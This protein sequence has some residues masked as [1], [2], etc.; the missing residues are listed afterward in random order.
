[1]TIQK[2]NNALLYGVSGDTKPTNYA[3]NTIFFEQDTGSTYRSVSGSWS[4]FSGASKTETLSNK[5]I[6]AELQT[7]ISKVAIAPHVRDT[8]WASPYPANVFTQG[9]MV[10]WTEMG[11]KAMVAVDSSH[12]ISSTYTTAATANSVQGGLKS[13]VA[14]TYRQFSPYI[15][16]KFSIG[17]STNNRVFV[18]FAAS[19]TI[20]TSDTLLGSGNAGVGVGWRSAT[21][22][23]WSVFNSDGTSAQTIT[24]TGVAK[25]TGVRMVEIKMDESVPNIVVKLDGTTYATLT[26]N[27]PSGT[28]SLCGYIFVEPS[29]ASAHVFKLY[30]VWYEHK[31]TVTPL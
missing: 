4:L 22:T 23:N 20:V 18:G 29:T 6:D 19:S 21:D 13:G 5:T 11:T 25:N 31:R 9:L 14:F 24:S 15:R 17:A 16:V 27:I 28:Q 8:G 2:V 3:D 7:D 26:T 12:G 30:N 10:G 1:M